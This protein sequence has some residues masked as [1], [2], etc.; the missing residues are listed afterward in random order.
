[1]YKISIV[2]LSA[3][4][5]LENGRID[6]LKIFNCIK[7]GRREAMDKKQKTLLVSILIV[8]ILIVVLIGYT[9]AKYYSNYN[10]QASA[11][12]AKWNFKVT[13]WST[14]QTEQISLLNTANVVSLEDGKIA[15]GASGQFEIELDATGSEVD[16]KYYIEAIESGNKPSNLLFS[17]NKNGVASGVQY[18]SLQE[19][20]EAELLGVIGKSTERKIENLQIVWNWPYETGDNIETITAED[21]EDTEAGTGNVEGQEN[22]FDYSFTLKVVGTQAKITT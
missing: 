1:M 15:P 2:H 22:V 18:A 11:Q 4:S 13:D 17:V 12:I 14:E 9:F 19:L 16:V 21:G 20:A 3:P 10:G 6:A 8:L 5:S 7:K